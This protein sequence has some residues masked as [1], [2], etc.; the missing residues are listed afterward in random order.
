MAYSRNRPRRKKQVKAKATVLRPKVGYWYWWAT[1]TRNRLNV[2]RVWA[3]RRYG[4]VFL[5]GSGLTLVENCFLRERR[6]EIP[7]LIKQNKKLIAYRE[8]SIFRNYKKPLEPD[9]AEN[10]DTFPL[11]KW[12]FWAVERKGDIPW[13]CVYERVARRWVL[14]PLGISRV[15]VPEFVGFF[16]G[17]ALTYSFGSVHQ[18]AFEFD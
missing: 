3:V 18:S 15:F 4:V 13:P 6:E 11:A 9:L 12:N 16:Y 5:D 17:D 7:R 2:G 10:N 1:P 8:R 14:V